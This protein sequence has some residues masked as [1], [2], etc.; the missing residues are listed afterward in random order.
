[1]ELVEKVARALATVLFCGETGT[2]KEIVAR[3]SSF[4]AAL[5]QTLSRR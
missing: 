5:L 1:M 4:L 2:G 3:H